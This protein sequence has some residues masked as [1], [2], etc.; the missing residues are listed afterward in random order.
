MKK[1]LLLIFVLFGL[2]IHTNASVDTI[3]VYSKKMSK[4][5]KTVVINPDKN[6][7][8]PVIYLLHGHGANYAQWLKDAPQLVE[9][10]T[11]TGSILV[12]P[13]GGYNSWYFD[14]PIDSSVRY[15]AFITKE[16]IPFIDSAYATKANRN[17][18][19]ITGLSMGGH[20]AFYLA[21]KHK[22]LFVAAGSICGGLDI[23][24]FPNNWQ[25]SKV[26]GSIDTN[27]RN[28]EKN[29]VINI[30]D[31]LKNNELQLIFDCGFDDFFLPV[32]RAVH[33]KLLAAKIKHDYIERSGTH[34]AAYWKNSIDYQLLFFRK[35]FSTN[36]ITQ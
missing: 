7:K 33:E 19:A 16:L 13:D 1:N 21:I 36:P 6:K 23:R 34:N 8:L 29:T 30:I 9:K 17:Y 27:S 12:M 32:N 15:E 14:S 26:L 28:W 31:S 20:G 3:L 11:E 35:Q 4:H 22:D 5:I 10:A 18:R 2:S 24:P 25:I